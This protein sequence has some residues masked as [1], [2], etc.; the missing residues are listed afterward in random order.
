M[1]QLVDARGLSCPQPVIMTLNKIKE[2][3]EGEIVILLDTDTSLENVKRAAG[4]KGWKVVDL[5]AES[6]DYRLVIGKQA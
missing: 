2:L 3:P 4:S 1:E 5:Q 6:E